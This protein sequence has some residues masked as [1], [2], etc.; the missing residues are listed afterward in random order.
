MDK[1]TKRFFEDGGELERTHNKLGQ[2]VTCDL[3]KDKK[4]IWK[5]LYEQIKT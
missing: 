2:C 5:D 4:E 3:G 1:N